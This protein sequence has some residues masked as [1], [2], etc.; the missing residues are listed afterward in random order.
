MD[1]IKITSDDLQIIALLEQMTGARVKDCIIG[2]TNVTIVVETGDIG[3]AVGQGGRNAKLLEQ[4]LKKRIKIIE[5]H[6]E[7]LTFVTAVIA[8]LRVRDARVEQD[9]VTLYPADSQT[10]GA[11]IGRGGSML[12]TY[13]NIVKRHFP[14]KEIKVE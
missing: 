8:P 10:R 1:K 13:E 7:L 2:E 14:I 3:K 4:R 6:P 12:R 9:I 5:Y 11:L